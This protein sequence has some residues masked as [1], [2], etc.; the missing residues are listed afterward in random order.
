M[1]QYSKANFT[2]NVPFNG[3]WSPSAIGQV[4]QTVRTRVWYF[5]LHQCGG[6]VTKYSNPK[7]FGAKIQWEVDVRNT[8]GSH[9]SEDEN[10]MLKS[11]M[12]VMFMILAYFGLN[13]TRLY[14]FYKREE[15]MD[16][17]TLII[18][19]VLFLEF[20]SLFCEVIHLLW[21]AQDGKGSFLF[22]F[23]N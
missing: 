10:G 5:V 6:E 8:D 3:N 7:N 22:N 14:R 20:M 12:L 16:Y 2:I 19:I 9:F 21:Y 1:L 17:P 15:S 23:G 11:Y 18:C 4:S 13:S